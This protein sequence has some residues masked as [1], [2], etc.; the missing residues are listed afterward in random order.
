HQAALNLMYLLGF[1][2]KPGNFSIFGKSDERYH[3]VGGN[4]K[5]PLAIAASLPS[6]SI[7][8]NHRM[9]SIKTN[10]DGTITMTFDTG[11]G[12]STTVTADQV[13]LCM[14]FAVLRTLDYRRAGFDNLKKTAITQLGAGI[15]A[16]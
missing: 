15:N 16:K 2:A 4:T 3:I 13:V 9:T 8:V 7:H 12:P 5:L 6:G 10:A 14:S 1:T 11:S